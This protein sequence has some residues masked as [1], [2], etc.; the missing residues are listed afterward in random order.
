MD[1]KGLLER[2]E[3]SSLRAPCDGY[4]FGLKF[5]LLTKL[6]LLPRLEKVSES[7]SSDVVRMVALFEKSESFVSWDPDQAGRAEPLHY[8]ILI[9]LGMR[10][11]MQ[12]MVS[13]AHEIEMLELESVKEKASVM[14]QKFGEVKAKIIRLMQM[15]R[16]RTLEFVSL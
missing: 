1:S 5:S 2:I 3:D 15:L 4:A 9:K 16:M 13:V 6:T 8:R 14:S 10:E 7:V 11:L 12:D